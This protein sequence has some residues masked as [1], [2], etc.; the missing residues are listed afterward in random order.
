MNPKYI[1]AK[2]ALKAARDLS[3]SSKGNLERALAEIEKASSMPV[4]VLKTHIWNI[5]KEK[6]PERVQ[7]YIDTALR[8]A[9]GN[10]INDK[11]TM[12]ALLRHAQKHSNMPL[13]QAVIDYANQEYQRS[14]PRRKYEALR[15]AL[16]QARG[17]T[18]NDKGTMD[19]WLRH[20]QEHSHSFM[21]RIMTYFAGLGIKGRYALRPVLSR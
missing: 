18:I 9:R 3:L 17:N 13:A 12:D 1:A 21:D 19:A 6:E 20:A 5:Y 14:E 15:V 4:E 16:R 10:T 8:Q 2:K 11:G 7:S